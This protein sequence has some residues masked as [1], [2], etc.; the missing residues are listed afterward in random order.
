M[1]LWKHRVYAQSYIPKCIWLV[2]NKCITVKAGKHGSTPADLS[3]ATQMNTDENS[4]TKVLRSFYAYS[5]ELQ[6]INR[7][8]VDPCMSAFIRTY[9]RRCGKCAKRF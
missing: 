6:A 7:Q 3:P 4:V 9:T 1:A 5:F 8:E 2:Y